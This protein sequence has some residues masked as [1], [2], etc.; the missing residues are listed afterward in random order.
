MTR[1][2]SVA[3]LSKRTSRLAW[4]SLAGLTGFG[5]LT[6]VLWIAWFV[7]T[8][9]LQPRGPGISQADDPFQPV[10]GVTITL[11][12]ALMQASTL[13]GLIALFQRG[14]RK[15]VPAGVT[16]CGCLLL[17]ALM[18]LAVLVSLGISA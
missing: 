5:L 2:S 18:L 8:I 7:Y 3:P 1:S 11:G 14:T 12:V 16:G 4:A 9:W 6:A 15:L 10:F 13:L 17:L